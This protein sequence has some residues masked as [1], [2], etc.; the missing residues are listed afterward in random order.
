MVAV[1][2]R[3]L[4]LQDKWPGTPNHNLGIPKGGFDATKWTDSSTEQ[5]PVGT[6]IQVYQ[7]FSGVTGYY[8]MMYSR[9]Y[10]QSV[11]NG[12]PIGVEKADL[13]LLGMAVF[14]HMC[15]STCLSA[16][17]TSNAFTVSNLATLGAGIHDATVTGQMGIACGTLSY[18][19]VTTDGDNHGGY[20][21]FWIDGVCPMDCTML[22]GVAHAGVDMSTGGNVAAGEPIYPQADTSVL[23]LDGAADLS[24][25][26][27]GYSFA[28][29]A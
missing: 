27:C 21:F 15:S 19:D 13:S 20:G 26:V 6:K 7:D 1:S 23:E 29:D 17:G 10:C 14:G 16:D 18:R 12:T 5:F 3:D 2:T 9:Y 28:T 25:N 22:S 24:N 8:T 4:V 11:N